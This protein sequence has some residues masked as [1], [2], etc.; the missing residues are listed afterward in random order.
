MVRGP[1]ARKWCRD[2]QAK[3]GMHGAMRLV[4]AALSSLPFS[5]LFGKVSFFTDCELLATSIIEEHQFGYFFAFGIR[6]LRACKYT[7]ALL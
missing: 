5:S 3:H 2:C 7:H 6:R 4:Q 1:G